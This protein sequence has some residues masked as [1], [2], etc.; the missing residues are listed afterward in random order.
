MR[1]DDPIT[2]FQ[3]FLGSLRMKVVKRLDTWIAPTTEAGTVCLRT[4]IEEGWLFMIPNKS[5]CEGLV[6]L[7]TAQDLKEELKPQDRFLVVFAGMMSH[8]KRVDF[9]VKV[10][11]DVAKHNPQV[12]C[13]FVGPSNSQESPKVNEEFGEALDEPQNSLSRFLILCMNLS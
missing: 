4:D 1:T 12:K 6:V 8:R 11:P 7:K 10:N 2:F 9:L 5:G 3:G 13:V